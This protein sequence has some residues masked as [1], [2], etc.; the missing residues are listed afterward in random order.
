MNITLVGFMGTGKS[1]T[2]KRLAKRLNWSFVDIDAEIE[3][4]AGKPINQIFS[5]HGEP[6]FRRLEQRWVKHAVRGNHQVL[7]TGGGVFVNEELRGMLRAS[8]P[9]ICLTARPQAI[10]DRVKHKVAG[11]PLLRC[12]DPMARIRTLLKERS[13]AYAKADMTV[14]TSDLSA[15]QVVERIWTLLSPMLCKGWQYL[16]EHGE[17]LSAKYGGQYV[18]VR[19]GRI[20]ASGKTQLEA[21]QNAPSAKPGLVTQPIS[22]PEGETGIYYIPP[23][24]RQSAAA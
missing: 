14:D 7:S 3:R 8:G 19:D 5:E 24:G 23:A 4:S 18:V 22:A 11:R 1:S 15:D 17:Q 9:V 6:V 12:D 2:G 13:Q 10:Y 20:V 21:Y 16:L